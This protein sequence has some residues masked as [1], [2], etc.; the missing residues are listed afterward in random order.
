MTNQYKTLLTSM[1]YKD[2]YIKFL[3][4]E[5]IDTKTIIM[6]WDHTNTK[7]NKRMII[8]L[9]TNLKTINKK[10]M[11]F[12]EKIKELFKW[13]KNTDLY[14]YTSDRKDGS[15]T[16]EKDSCRSMF[17]IDK[18]GFVNNYIDNTDK[19]GDVEDYYDN[20]NRCIYSLSMNIRPDCDYN[21]KVFIRNKTCHYWIKLRNNVFAKSIEKQKK[22][23]EL[24]LQKSKKIDNMTNVVF[25]NKCRE[26]GYKTKKQAW[27]DF[28]DMYANDEI[29]AD[30][31]TR[32]IIDCGERHKTNRLTLT[33]DNTL[34]LLAEINTIDKKYHY[35]RYYNDNFNEYVFRLE[36]KQ[37]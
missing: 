1:T 21:D 18:C 9:S 28:N 19:Y 23:S 13:K 8:D 7:L 35:N 10:N 30:F 3:N 15:I 20:L 25:Y 32:C 17:T 36:L 22:I 24:K 27:K 37:K 26:Y 12:I 16:F 11:F 14:I 5:C 31:I 2:A 6:T 33:D 29:D 34:K 4:Y